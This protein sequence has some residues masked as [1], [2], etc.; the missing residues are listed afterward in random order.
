MKVSRKTALRTGLLNSFPGI[1]DDVG[2]FSPLG[3]IAVTDAK[4]QSA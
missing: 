4:G 3:G 2:D 1:E